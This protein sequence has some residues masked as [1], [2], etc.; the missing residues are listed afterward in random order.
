[1]KGLQTAGSVAIR[2][3]VARFVV[4]LRVMRNG[5]GGEIR[6]R[7]GCS[8]TND[9]S[10]SYMLYRIHSTQY[11]TIPIVA[12]VSA[13]TTSSVGLG[14]IAKQFRKPAAG[15]RIGPASGVRSPYTLNGPPTATGKQGL[16]DGPSVTDSEDESDGGA[17]RGGRA[18]RGP[19]SRPALTLSLVEQRSL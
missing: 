9:A 11:N 12:R 3:P 4:V 5:R 7:P 15:S 10:R 2:Q 19:P 14:A 17:G 13:H 1:M 8:V 16:I 6:T 18:Q